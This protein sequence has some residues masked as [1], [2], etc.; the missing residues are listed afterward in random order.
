MKIKR[1]VLISGVAVGILLMLVLAT[2][3]ML[4]K[5]IERERTAYINQ[6]EY[7]HLANTMRT[8]SNYLTDKARYY[9]QTA[10][11]QHLDDYWR[12]VKETKRREHVINRL[13]ELNTPE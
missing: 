7:V 13:K 5:S 4:Q 9:V 6:L 1:L 3:I 12:E 10:N 2:V 11:K 8:A